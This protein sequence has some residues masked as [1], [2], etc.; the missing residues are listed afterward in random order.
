MKLKILCG[1]DKTPAFHPIVMGCSGFMNITGFRI[2][3]VF[4]RYMRTLYEFDQLVSSRMH[5]TAS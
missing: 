3:G 4:N 1:Q 2:V 5:T